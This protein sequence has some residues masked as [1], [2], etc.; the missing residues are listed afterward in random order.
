MGSIV[1]YVHYFIQGHIY[2]LYMFP[3]RRRIVK[4]ICHT[5]H[6]SESNFLFSVGAE[7][8]KYYWS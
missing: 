3:G 2:Y 7:V 1:S 6:K 4:E 5:S 8:I